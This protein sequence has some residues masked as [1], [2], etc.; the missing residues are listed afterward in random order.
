V[1]ANIRRLR[2]GRGWSLRELA[3]KL[4]EAGYPLGAPALSEMERGRRRIDVEDV[5]ALAGVYRAWPSDLVKSDRERQRDEER[6]GMVPMDLIRQIEEQVKAEV[7]ARIHQATTVNLS[8][9]GTLTAT[10]EVFS[11]HLEAERREDE[12]EM[13]G[14]G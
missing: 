10:A 14:E 12:Q 4:A 2:E 8:G 3:T 7:I 11:P 9:V 1:G 13:G 6:A 5:A